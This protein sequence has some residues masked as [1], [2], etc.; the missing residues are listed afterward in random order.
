MFRY[1]GMD[2]WVVANNL[3]K[4]MKERSDWRADLADMVCLFCERG[5]NL[6]SFEKTMSKDGQDRLKDI[7]TAYSLVPRMIKSDPNALTLS[8]VG[9]LLPSA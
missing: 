1:V 4:A 6:T 3:L 9:T 8:R 7:K 5:T 2:I